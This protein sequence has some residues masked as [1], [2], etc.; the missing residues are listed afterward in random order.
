M[1]SRSDTIVNN[2]PQNDHLSMVSVFNVEIV[3]DNFYQS[4]LTFLT[5]FHDSIDKRRVIR[6]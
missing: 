1:S 4:A 3:A 6:T 2:Q 5:E